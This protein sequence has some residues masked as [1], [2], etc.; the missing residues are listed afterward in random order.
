V[1]V[2]EA[3]ARL[4]APRHKAELYRMWTAGHHAGLTHPAALEAAGDFRRSVVVRRLLEHLL[5]GTRR[6]ASIAALVKSRGDL[7]EPFE[8]AILTLG[9]ESGRL[10]E[11]LRLLAEHFAAEHRLMLWVKKKLAYPMMNALAATFIAPFPLLYFGRAGAYLAT[12]AGGLLL[13]GLSGGGL[14]LAVARHYAGKPA[15]V[16]VRLLRALATAAEAGLPLGRAVAL[17]VEAAAST[18]LASHVARQG[19]RVMSQSL[20]D[21][22]RNAPL[23]TPEMAAVLDVAD[24]TGNYTDTLRKLADLYDEGFR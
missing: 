17:G 22:F 4:D 13:L 5:A 10:E 6:R 2:A 24:R 14:L 9:E 11:C 23:V 16:R 18:E 19:G 1:D 15:L 12:V 8:A 7:F 3:L 20:A 21:T